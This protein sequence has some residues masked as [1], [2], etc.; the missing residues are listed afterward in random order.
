MFGVGRG[1]LTLLVV[2]VTLAGCSSS[3]LPPETK[4]VTVAPPPAATPAAEPH[5]GL[6][7]V[8]LP[9]GTVPACCGKFEGQEDWLVTTPYDFTVQSLRQQL[10]I[11]HGYEGLPWC[12]QQINGK[13]GYTQ[14][15][16]A[17]DKNLIQVSVDHSGKVT[18]L[19]QPDDTGRQGCD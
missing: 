14:W 8:T 2:A 1:S 4:T 17:D 11:L 9:A 7:N 16:W 12:S 18:I 15:N 19:R 5:S 13:L 10:P 3:S 6:I